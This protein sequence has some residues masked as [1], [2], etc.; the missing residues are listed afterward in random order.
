MGKLNLKFYFL[1][2]ICC[3]LAD[4]VPDFKISS[5]SIHENHLSYFITLSG[6]LINIINFNSYDVTLSVV[7][8]RVLFLRYYS[9]SGEM[10]LIPVESIR[11]NKPRISANY[12]GLRSDEILRKNVQCESIIY[13]H[14]PNENKSPHLYHRI[15]WGKDPILKDPFWK[16][17]EVNTWDRNSLYTTP[18]LSLLIC[19][20]DKRQTCENA[21]HKNKWIASVLGGVNAVW[22]T[23]IVQIIKIL[24]IGERWS[25][26]CPYCNP[27]NP[28]ETK[29]IIPNILD[30]NTWISHG[31]LLNQNYIPHSIKVVL[32]WG[33]T[34]PYGNIK[35]KGINARKSLL[36]LIGQLDLKSETKFLP[37]SIDIHATQQL[38]PE[39][40]TIKYRGDYETD[41]YEWK[42]I[43]VKGC[44]KAV[45][46]PAK[47][48]PYI[49]R[50]SKEHLADLHENA[51]VFQ[52]EQFRFVSCHK[53]AAHWITQ[54]NQLVFAFDTLTWIL[55][56]IFLSVI[57]RILNQSL[58]GLNNTYWDSWMYLVG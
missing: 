53:Q 35:E 26:L 12:T 36:K 45:H 44:S 57:A 34:E 56:I 51:L 37:F 47:F 43:P 21:H 54:L 27:C 29:E 33:S 1:M 50:N 32:F 18:K 49:E 3:I 58:Q 25:M 20:S 11:K 10:K 16:A 4:A 6:C 8:Q 39:N 15:Y 40:T 52:K 5:E 31:K 55:I 2:L 28:L 24:H 41:R 48:R 7:R 19:K 17:N 9:Y 42:K 30:R 22:F 13:L 23:E 46:Y 38:F 14:P